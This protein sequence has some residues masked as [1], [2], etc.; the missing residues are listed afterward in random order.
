MLEPPTLGMQPERQ[1]FHIEDNFDEC[2]YRLC[3]GPAHVLDTY[4]AVAAAVL[5]DRPMVSRIEYTDGDYDVRIEQPVKTINLA[6][7]DQLFNYSFR[8]PHKRD[9]SSGVSG[10]GRVYR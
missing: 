4:N 7:R 9:D 5:G 2:Q 1:T 3:E 6:E 8:R 10:S